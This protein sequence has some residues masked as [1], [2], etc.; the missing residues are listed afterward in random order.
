[1]KPSDFKPLYFIAGCKSKVNFLMFKILNLPIP[2]RVTKLF[3]G[4]RYQI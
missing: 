3:P 2:V 1:M 4:F